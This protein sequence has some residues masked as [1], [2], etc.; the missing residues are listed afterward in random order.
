MTGENTAA[1]EVVAAV[2]TYGRAIRESR[3][4]EEVC[5]AYDRAIHQLA[6]AGLGQREA[7]HL[8]RYADANRAQIDRTKTPDQRT[9][10][11]RQADELSDKIRQA[12]ERAL[13]NT[14]GLP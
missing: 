1:R 7:S 11:G 3:P 5:L 2:H 10:A 14:G 12:V 9:A 13:Q 4:P 8:S 6:A